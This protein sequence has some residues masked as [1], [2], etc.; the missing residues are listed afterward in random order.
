MHDSDNSFSDEY[1]IAESLKNAVDN[2]QFKEIS[3]ICKKPLFG[4]LE[5]EIV[6]QLKLMA[7]NPP[8]SLNQEAFLNQASQKEENKEDIL[9]KLVL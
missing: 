9:N 8:P 7:L 6:K 3:Q 4:F 2:R 1:N 5:N